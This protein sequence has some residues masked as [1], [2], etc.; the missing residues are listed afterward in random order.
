MIWARLWIR[1]RT[2]LE[3]CTISTVISGAVI[4]DDVYCRRLIYYLDE[5]EALSLS[6]EPQCLE[7]TFH[8]GVD[9]TN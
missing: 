4:Q 7:A 5:E 2:R 1:G 6:P 9:S 8:K 3:M